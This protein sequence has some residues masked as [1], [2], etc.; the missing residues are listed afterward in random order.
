MPTIQTSTC[1][2]RYRTIP[3]YGGIKRID[4]Q[5][6]NENLQLLKKILDKNGV[7]FLLF[8]GTLL[9]CVRE[10]D[11]ITHDE[12]ID[13]A[14][15]DED[16][17]KLLDSL[18]ELIE[19][20]FQIA[21]YDKRGLLSIIRKN[22]YIDFYFFVPYK[23]AGIRSCCGSLVFEKSLTEIAE[24]DFKG[25]KYMGPEDYEQHFRLEYGPD[26][27]TPVQYFDFKPSKIKLL[28]MKVRAI[29]KELLP[30]FI[31]RRVEKK[32]EKQL[33]NKYLVKLERY[34]GYEKK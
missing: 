28:K 20:G 16:R 15:L 18:P 31:C 11:F 32:Y 2:I 13:L 9:G 8:Y 34:N 4:K 22:E 29:G 19:N 24:Y 12:D 27:R 1:K 26:W 30:D 7:T 14:M 3:I 5:Q 33:E 23:E 6:A 10:H 21:R 25:G 17:Q